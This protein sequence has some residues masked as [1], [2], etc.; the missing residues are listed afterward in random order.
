MGEGP[1]GTLET[2]FHI[3]MSFELP[4]QQMCGDIV[5]D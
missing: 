3:E 5:S 2:S 4:Q 1:T